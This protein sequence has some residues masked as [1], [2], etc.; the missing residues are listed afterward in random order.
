MLYTDRISYCFQNE[1]YK[2]IR[3]LLIE[4]T[5]LLQSLSFS[6]I[7]LFLEER[8]ALPFGVLALFSLATGDDFFPGVVTDAGAGNSNYF[9]LFKTC[10]MHE[11]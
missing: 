6:L 1:W 7:L 3:F 11:E 9:T 2:L 4:L 5:V 8:P 10:T